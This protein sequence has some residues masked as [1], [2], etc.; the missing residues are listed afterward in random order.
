LLFSDFGNVLIGIGVVD[1]VQCDDGGELFVGESVDYSLDRGVVP[2]FERLL[3]A[4]FVEA[5]CY[6]RRGGSVTGEL[7][8]EG[9]DSVCLY[10]LSVLFPLYPIPVELTQSDMP[11]PD[12]SP[13][14]HQIPLNPSY[15]FST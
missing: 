13:L 12:T 2:I 11:S 7:A 8:L 6:D 9:V 10:F 5:A 15:D 3:E 4:E 1:F 14:L